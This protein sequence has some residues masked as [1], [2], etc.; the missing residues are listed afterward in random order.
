MEIL[1]QSVGEIAAR[2]P[3]AIEVF[4]RHGIEF[5]C[6]GHAS[7][8]NVCKEKDLDPSQVLREI[9]EAGQEVTSDFRV[10]EEASAAEIVSHL[11][12][13]Y[14]VPQRELMDQ[15]ADWAV[16]VARRHGEKDARLLALRETF[17]ALKDELV[18]HFTR[19]E[20]IL[21]PAIVAGNPEAA[22]ALLAPLGQEH[23]EAGASL[24]EI[25]K[26]CDG[27]RI[28]EEACNTWRGL[29]QGLEKLERGLHKHIHLEN[30]VLFP[31]VRAGKAP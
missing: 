30:N 7:F 11:L 13:D 19:E 20:E 22:M 28:P 3:G 29:L 26:L 5:C 10:W 24:E 17:L 2:K 14:H 12:E 27:F 31:K 23:E 8:L 25:R 18:E 4:Y 16:R 9:E 1:E 6:G 21:F 15:C